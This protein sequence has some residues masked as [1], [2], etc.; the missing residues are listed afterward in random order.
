MKSSLS[1]EIMRA[2]SSLVCPGE[3]TDVEPGADVAGDHDSARQAAYQ[4]A[5]HPGGRQ[6]TTAREASMA[7]PRSMLRYG[8]IAMLQNTV[9]K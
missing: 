7:E 2:G 4:R 8:A 5:R 9:R 1:I 6:L 3:G